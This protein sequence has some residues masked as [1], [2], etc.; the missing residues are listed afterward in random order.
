MRVEGS[1]M[2]A[3]PGARP[4]LQRLQLLLGRGGTDRAAERERRVLWTAAASALAKLMSVAAA[5]ISLPLTLHYLGAERFGMWMTIGSLIALLSFADLGI[6]N[7]VLSAVAQALGRD[8]RAAIQR[9]VSSAIVLL[10]AL[11]LFIVLVFALCYPWVHWPAVFNVHSALAAQ[12]AGP[13][14]AVFTVCLVAGSALAVV[15]KAQ[16]GLQMGFVANLWQCAG[17]LAALLGVLA[18]IQAEGSLPWLVAALAGAPVL[19]MLC[20]GI[21]FFWRMRPDLRF[22]W[23]H[24]SASAMRSLAGVGAFFFVLQL[25][26]AVAYASDSLVI[27]Q[28]LGATA[29][30]EF[31]VPDKLFGLVTLALGMLLGPLWPAYGEAIERGDR[32]WVLRTL[33]RSLLSAIA[34]ACVAGAVLVALGPALIG[35]WVQHAVTPGLGLLVGLAVW[36][37]VEAAGGALA[38]FLNGAHVIKLQVWMALPTAA[39][40]VVLKVVLVSHFGVAGVPWAATIAWLLFTALPLAWAMPSLLRAVAL[41]G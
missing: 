11:G 14:L 20:N 30:A 21:F 25:V 10:C 29:V 39:V 13:A 17:S 31:A 33:K 4:L 35:A 8:D 23:S 2:P 24:V 37:V 1:P 12:E 3:T 22:R 7:G 18:V 6:A 16:L 32:A 27:A 40:A 41:R 5:L 26:A 9:A 15:Q 38:V 28:L 36:R 19:A 34:F